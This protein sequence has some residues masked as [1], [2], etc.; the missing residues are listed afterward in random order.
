MRL[1]DY[2]LKDGTIADDMSRWIV[3]VGWDQNNWDVKQFPTAADI[4]T[5]PWRESSSL[6]FAMYTR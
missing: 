4:E 1:R 2:V 5:E 3:G 6:S